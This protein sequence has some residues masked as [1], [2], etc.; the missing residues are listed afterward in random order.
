MKNKKLLGILTGICVLVL[1]ASFALVPRFSKNKSSR[2]KNTLKVGI[3]HSLSGNMAISEKPVA[4]AAVLAIHE[5]NARGGLDGKKIEPILADG[6]SDP[7]VFQKEAERLLSQEKVSV[8]F[9]CWTSA[10][11]KAV[12]PVVEKHQA[13]LFYPV[14]Y[15][16]V[17]N[18]P[19]IVYLGAAPNQQLIPA[20]QWALDHLG[21]SF[22]L[23]GSDYVYPRIANAIAQ[24]VIRYSGGHVT[25]E[26]YVPL[27]SDDFSQ[28]IKKLQAAKPDIILNTINGKGNVAFFE[29]LHEAKINTDKI[30]VL[31]LSLGESEIKEVLRSFKKRHPKEFEHFLKEHIAGTYTCWSYFE[32][33]DSP[34]NQAFVAKFKKKYG[35]D[36]PVS[37]PMEAAYYG[38]HLWAN[39]I[40]EGA[41]AAN[42]R[43]MINTLKHLSLPTPSGI[44]TLDNNNHARK[45]V[46]IGR[47]NQSGHFD[48]LWSSEGPI[49]PVP[50]PFFK[51]RG[52]WEKLLRELQE[53][54]KGRWTASS[55]QVPSGEKP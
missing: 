37:D 23:V 39:A 6:K 19:N 36:F 25:G 1:I 53:Q 50:Y 45:M 13:L 30:P 24:E 55:P 28:V 47:F 8:I 38:V 29:A 9:G 7:D 44:L 32:K 43:D 27:E 31:S 11:R 22:F 26:A 17:E 49:P 18:S 51:S 12:R 35:P 21:K 20:T 54:W 14:Q 40:Q 5:I 42:S 33:I 15:E 46:R 48:I 10:S 16:G 41:D 2:S 34:L 4:A 52:Y 3:L